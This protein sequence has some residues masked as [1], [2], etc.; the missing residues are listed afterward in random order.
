MGSVLYSGSMLESTRRA[1]VKCS[2][3]FFIIELHR[4][5]QSKE[6]AL[7][8]GKNTKNTEYNNLKEFR[9]IVA[10][11]LGTCIFSEHLL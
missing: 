11:L 10:L 8:L 3:H 1:V 7:Q 2:L 5:L 9:L 6:D 4:R